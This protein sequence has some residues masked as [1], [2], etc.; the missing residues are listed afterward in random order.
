MVPEAD[1]KRLQERAQKEKEEAYK[2]G[3]ADGYQMG[4]SKGMEEANRTT[5]VFNKLINDVKNNQ[6]EIYQD[7]EL[8]VIGLVIALTRK[9]ITAK[10]EI[11]PEIVIG[12]VQKA[13]KLLL[14][15]SSLHIKVSPE[16]IGFIREN[17]NRLYALDDSIQKIELE[18][19]RRVGMGGCI[20]ETES[21]NVDAR[22]EKEFEHITDALIEANRSQQEE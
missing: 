5:G 16:Q 19:D 7:A 18:P 6:E 14:D 4:L 3:H 21:G 11:D 13:V 12:S 15:K 22:I 10:A 17:L 1:Y 20:V 9:I 2:N 8:E